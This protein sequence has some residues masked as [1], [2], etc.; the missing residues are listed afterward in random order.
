MINE[1]KLEQFISD[2]LCF[3][4]EEQIAIDRLDA[5]LNREYMVLEEELNDEQRTDI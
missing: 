5:N 2:E 1:L 3:D 4:I